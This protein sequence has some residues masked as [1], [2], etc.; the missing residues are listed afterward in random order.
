MKQQLFILAIATLVVGGMAITSQK[1]VATDPYAILNIKET[2]SLPGIKRACIQKL[3]LLHAASKHACLFSWANEQEEII[4][5]TEICE[6]FDALLQQDNRWRR[7]ENSPELAQRCDDGDPTVFWIDHFHD[8]D[9]EDNNHGFSN[10]KTYSSEHRALTHCQRIGDYEWCE[11]A[12][13]TAKK[14]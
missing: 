14:H 8:Y 4:K 12:K 13:K 2:A 5:L 1:M 10:C 7:T 11:E 6:A 9:D 3:L